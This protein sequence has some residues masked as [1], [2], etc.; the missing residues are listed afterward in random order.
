MEVRETLLNFI[1]THYDPARLPQLALAAGMTWQ[2]QTGASQRE[3]LAA[4]LLRVER[5]GMAPALLTRLETDFPNALPALQWAGASAGHASPTATADRNGLASSISPTPWTAA[6]APAPADEAAPDPS[7]SGAFASA[8]LLTLRDGVEALETARQAAAPPLRLRLQSDTGDLRDPANAPEDWEGR[9][10]NASRA[11]ILPYRFVHGYTLPTHWARRDREMAELITQVR[12]NRHRLLSL[13][14]IGG[15]GKSALTRKLLDELPKHHIHLDGALWF[16]FY[17]EPDFDRFLTEACRYLIPGFEPR[18]HPSPYEKALLLREAMETGRY[19]FVLDGIEVLMVADRSRKDFGSFQDR[20]LRDFLQGVCEGKHSQLLISSRFPLVDLEDNDE[21]YVLQLAD[22][23]L[24][25][26][27][28]L[29]TLHGVAD[30]TTGREAIYRRFGSHALTLQVISDFLM[31]FHEGEPQGVADIQE[32]EPDAPQGI[33]LQAAL[34][35]YW[36]RLHADERFFMTRMSAFRGGVDERSLIVLNRSG[37]AFS[38]DYRGMVQRLVQSP[39]VSIERREGHARLTS[40]PLIKTFF[41]ERMGENER[42]QTHR[43]LKDYA[44][45]LPLPDRPHTLEDYEPL[46]AACH[47]CLQVGLYTEAYQIYRRNN[48]DNALRWWGHYAVALELLEPLREAS[49]GALPTWQSER[50]QRSW[51]ENETALLAT[52]RGDTRMAMERFQ[53]SAEMDAEAGDGQGESASWQ[54]LASI[55]TQR[56]DFAGALKALDRSRLLE[57]V[58]GRY[59]KEDMIAGL[60]G[61]CRMELGEAQ[62][63]FDLLTHAMTLSQQRSNLRA[64]CYWTWRIGDLFLRAN[65]GERGQKYFSQAL[66][67]A[68][69][70]QF[71]DFE[72]HALRGLADAARLQN[73]FDTARTRNMEA[74]RIARALGNPF[75]ENETQLSAAQIA[76]ADA[77][78]SETIGQA[79]QVLDRADE[80]GYATHGGLARLVLARAALAAHDYTALNLHVSSVLALLQTT[81]HAQTQQELNRLLEAEPS[82]RALQPAPLEK[83]S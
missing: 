81:R 39:L 71:R 58:L 41:Y 45:G 77:N 22:L 38:P 29:L 55:L 66:D 59:E 23:S 33:R 1:E 36:Q 83:L 25:S 31:R 2:A 60:E 15:T 11:A 72:G 14:A 63:A 70:E 10:A 79:Q 43:A 61:V 16:S 35:G 26:A 52:L 28:E 73:Q 4:L 78:A 64:V 57:T 19:L 47:H 12:E 69:A 13:I 37:D 62:T 68:R 44:Q 7:P 54:N 9:A 80:S 50:W 82:L 74:L 18:A 27:D 3:R 51:V 56:G 6:E 49:Q 20:A 8:P 30:D 21:Q 42:D 24:E 5:E 32:V 67:L 53:H 40:H 34:D 48:M 75:L 17:I 76:E 65:R 46:L